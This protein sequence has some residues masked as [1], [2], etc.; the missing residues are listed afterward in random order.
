MAYPRSP[1][2]ASTK[3]GAC[4]GW[5]LSKHKA[6][7]G[8]PRGFPGLETEQRSLGQGTRR[9]HDNWPGGDSVR[10]TGVTSSQDVQ[11][12]P[13]K[14]TVRLAHLVPHLVV[15]GDALPV[16]KV[17]AV[18][19]GR[20]RACPRR[21][22]AEPRSLTPTLCLPT[23]PSTQRTP[24]LPLRPGLHYTAWS[25]GGTSGLSIPG[26][27]TLWFL[28]RACVLGLSAV[29]SPRGERLRN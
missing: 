25:S 4:A 3:T 8:G 9:V 12:R 18:R 20:S 27:L 7:Q 23:Q 6:D 2:G 11:A 1:R 21:H 19:A 15:H 5:I 28:L 22:R 29:P 24:F 17:A 16:L 10:T 26:G 13:G 14:A